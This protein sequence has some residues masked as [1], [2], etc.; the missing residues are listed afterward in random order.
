MSESCNT[1]RYRLSPRSLS[2]AAGLPR[3]E[4]H[5]R[6]PALVSHD[7]HEHPAMPVHLSVAQSAPM[8]GGRVD[9]AALR[10]S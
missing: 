2:G 1:D 10:S 6:K 3:T 5:L 9:V 7:G 8:D 4:S